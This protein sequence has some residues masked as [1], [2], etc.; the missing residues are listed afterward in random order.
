M[1][2]A[3]HKSRRVIDPSWDFS[4]CPSTDPDSPRRTRRSSH[5]SRTSPTRSRQF[6]FFCRRR[7]RNATG[8]RQQTHRPACGIPPRK[9]DR[10]SGDLGTGRW[11][12]GRLFD[13]KMAA[14]TNTVA[15]E[16]AESR[17]ARESNRERIS[18]RLEKRDMWRP[19]LAVGT[20]RRRR[21]W[22][23]GAAVSETGPWSWGE[24]LKTKRAA[25]WR[26]AAGRQGRSWKQGLPD[27]PRRIIISKNI[28]FV[29]T[30]PENNNQ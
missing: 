7:G 26:L 11:W 21:G 2:M 22:P 5:V 29:V 25:V 24:V 4:P 3:S 12:S 27:L 9:G 28:F 13:G 14:V 30:K 17:N 1:V 19:F 23:R 20:G 10:R 15:V 16:T 6:L 8:S 18:G